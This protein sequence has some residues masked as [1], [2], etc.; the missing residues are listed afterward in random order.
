VYLDED[1]YIL[2]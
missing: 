2:Y 1:F